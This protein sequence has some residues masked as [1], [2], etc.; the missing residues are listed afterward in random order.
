MD[1]MTH[2][3]QHEDLIFCHLN[4]TSYSTIVGIV[5]I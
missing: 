3:Y 2:T 5:I 1:R 4:T